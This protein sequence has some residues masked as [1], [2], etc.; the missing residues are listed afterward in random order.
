M[1]NNDYLTDLR[2]FRNCIED[3]ANEVQ[4]KLAAGTQLTYEDDIKIIVDNR[5]QIIKFNADVYENLL[6]LVDTEI[7]S[8]Q[9]NCCEI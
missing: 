6:S 2:Y 3:K 8:E 5:T 1:K 9:S 7:D 4:D